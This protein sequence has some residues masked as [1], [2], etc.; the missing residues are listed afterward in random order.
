VYTPFAGW[1]DQDWASVAREGLE[2]LHP[3]ARRYLDFIA[4]YLGLD[5]AAVGVGPSRDATIVL[6]MPAPP[7]VPGAAGRQT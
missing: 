5:L 6:Q 4:D 2:A 7:G 1:P 3:N